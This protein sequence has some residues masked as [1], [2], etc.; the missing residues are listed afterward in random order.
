LLRPRPFPKLIGREI[1]VDTAIKALQASVSL[2]FYGKEGVGK[3]SLLRYLAYRYETKL[4]FPDGVIYL[5][6]RSKPA[7]DLLQAL[8]DAFYDSNASIKPTDTQIRHAL[9]DKRAL[10]LLD[11]LRLTKDE[12]EELINA[13]PNC[14]LLLSSH[15]QHFW[16]EGESIALEGLSAE[17]AIFLLENDLGR[18]L[19]E[20]E[21]SV[22]Q[23][24]CNILNGHPLK[25]LQSLASVKQGISSLAEVVHQYRLES[26]SEHSSE[27]AEVMATSTEEERRVL[28]VLATLG[29]VGLLVQQVAAITELTDTTKILQALQQRDLVQFD[30]DRYSVNGSLAEVLERT[31][32]LSLWLQKSLSYFT[33]LAEQCKTIPNRILNEVDAFLH[34]LTK[35]SSSGLWAEVLQLG[36]LI[37]G[38][39]AL[40]KY[41]GTWGNVLQLGLKAARQLKQQASEALMLHQIGTRAV[42]LDDRETAKNALN[43]A[44]QIRESLGDKIGAAISRHNL[45]ILVAIIAASAALGTVAATVSSGTA[46]A[47]A[48]AGVGATIAGTAS[49]AS[50]GTAIA[51]ITLPTLIKVGAAVVILTTGAVTALSIAIEYSEILK[52]FT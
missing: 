45:G 33:N 11:D 42:C 36:Q 1:E 47:T 52:S 31:W 19:E 41:W 21:K 44:I 35:A 8:F 20:D 39:F 29:G 13:A 25:L 17:K 28:A 37:E 49:T 6:A 4:L 12:L 51:T 15:N 10:I 9:Q 3:T 38:A 50:T 23:V 5:I 32:D 30:G 14:T 16:G 27:I 40:N 26:G 7:L 24:L 18:S 22:A 34:L 48:T 46:A 2:E 43:Q